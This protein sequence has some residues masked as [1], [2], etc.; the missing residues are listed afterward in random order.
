MDCVRSI[1]LSL[2]LGL[3]CT[4]AHAG[5]LP[6]GPFGHAFTATDTS[7]VWTLNT[8]SKSITMH[9]H[10]DSANLAG[11]VATPDEKKAFWERMMWEGNGWKKASCLRFED[12]DEGENLF[13]HLSKADRK[14]ISWLEDFASE[15]FHWSQMAGVMEIRPQGAKP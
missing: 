8:L 3:A 4:V 5:T 6:D 1:T 12:P 11:G 7:T 9:R 13:C 15:H 2:I 14:G 10:G